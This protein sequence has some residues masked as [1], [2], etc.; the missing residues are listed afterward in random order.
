MRAADLPRSAWFLVAANLVPLVGVLLFGW[1]LG[2]VMVLFWAENIVVGVFAILRLALVAGWASLFL[3]PFFAFHY[4][5]FCAGH[6]VFVF[7]MFA[8]DLDAQDAVYV[9]LPGV[10]A[11]LVSHGASFVLNFLRGGERDRMLGRAPASGDAMAV[12]AEQTKRMGDAGSLMVAPY[13]RIVVLHLTIIGG[14]FLLVALGSPVWALALLV[15][16][17]SGMDLR[18]HVKERQRAAPSTGGPEATT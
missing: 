11:V 9:L 2:V 16:L 7:A 10:L 14:G 4:G 13:R 5:M 12:V 18:A 3:V 17:K 8:R 6:A 15:V 1:D